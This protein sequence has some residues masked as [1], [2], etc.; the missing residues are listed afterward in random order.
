MKK[1]IIIIF[2]F[3]SYSHAQ[4]NSHGNGPIH[5]GNKWIYSS[6]DGFGNKAVYEIVDSTV[7]LDSIEYGLY[8]SVHNDLYWPVRL[9]EDNFYVE[10]RDTSYKEPDN[11]MIFYKKGALPGES[12]TQT[13]PAKTDCSWIYTAE[14]LD[15]FSLNVFDSLV[16]ARYIYLDFGLDI[17]YELWTDE[18]G[19]ITDADFWGTT[20]TLV[21]CI[22]DGKAYGDTIISTIGSAKT[23]IPQ[24][25][26]L[27]PNYPNPF[28]SATIIPYSLNESAFVELK[29]YSITGREIS[30]LISTYQPAGVYKLKWN[31]KGLSSGVYFIHL[32]VAGLSKTQ[33]VILIR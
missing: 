9:R 27:L 21:G 19:L 33:K 1:L 12:W 26:D 7:T 4:F 3:Y 15:T 25:F 20:S 16:V 28:N 11:E 18:F 29:I 5:S 8:R 14:V 6:P 24:K 13:V 32:S 2:L 23:I 30:T 17:Y 31:P 10:K 22:I